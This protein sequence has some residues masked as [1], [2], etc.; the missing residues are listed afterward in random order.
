M[1]ANA[2]RLAGKEVHASCTLFLA[3]SGLRINEALPLDWETVDR[4]GEISHVK[5]CLNI[6]LLRNIYVKTYCI[7]NNNMA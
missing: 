7:H 2:L 5:R 1:I 6:L 3:F 4:R